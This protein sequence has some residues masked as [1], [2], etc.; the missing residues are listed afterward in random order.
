MSTFIILWLIWAFMAA[1]ISGKKGHSAVSFFAD[2]QHRRDR[3]GH[4]RRIGDRGQFEQPDAVRELV[5]QG[6]NAHVGW[7]AVTRCWRERCS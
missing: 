1:I 7:Q 3:V 4:R 2:A 5:G 6:D